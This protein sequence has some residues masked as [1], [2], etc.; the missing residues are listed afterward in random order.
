MPG[1]YPAP[2]EAEARKAFLGHLRD[3]VALL[4]GKATPQ[5]LDEYKR[6]IVNL[7]DKVARAHRESG[8]RE[9]PVSDT[10]R[11]A[12][13]A[14]EDMRFVGP[15]RAASAPGGGEEPALAA[16]GGGE[17][18]VYVSLGTVFEDRPVFFRD[19]ARA[20]A[21]PGRRVILSVGRITAQALGTLPAGVSAHARVDQLAVLGAAA[22]H[23]PASSRDQ[24]VP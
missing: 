14:G 1:S 20:L 21:R 2:L 3:A 5:E 15:L 12:S 16:L 8:R 13:A 4:K 6:F 7:S 22:G 23:H 24:G 17:E 18:L 19:A 11:A 10:E 9:E